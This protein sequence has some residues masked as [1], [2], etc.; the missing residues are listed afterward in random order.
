MLKN[1]CVKTTM[2]LNALTYVNINININI[3]AWRNIPK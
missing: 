2:T 3:S 1:S